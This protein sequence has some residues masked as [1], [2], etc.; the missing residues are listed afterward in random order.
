M[1]QE[2]FLKFFVLR[3][4]RGEISDMELVKMTSIIIIYK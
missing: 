2:E 4:F 1:N 3:H